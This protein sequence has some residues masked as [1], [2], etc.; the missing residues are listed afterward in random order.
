MMRSFLAALMLCAFVIS[1]NANLASARN[2]PAVVK[3]GVPEDGVASTY[4][5]NDRHAWS[6]TAHCWKVK[7]KTRCERVDPQAMTAAHRSLPFN[8]TVRVT[9]KRNGRSAIVRINDRGPYRRGRILDLTPA[10]AHAIGSDGLAPVRVERVAAQIV[11]HPAGCPARAFCGCGAALEV[12]GRNI[13]ELWLAAN[14]FKFPRAEPAPG[15]VAVRRHHVFVIREVRA[16]GLVLAYDPNS[17][18]GLTRIHLRSLRGY[19]VVNP[20]A[21][22]RYA[23]AS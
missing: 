2:A 10:A 9:N 15:M 11:A 20:R 1:G 19:V 17:G 18:R 3:Y 4:A 16:P 14:W 6:A 21:G 5:N 8:S 23:S 7:H 13:R 12:F 22:S